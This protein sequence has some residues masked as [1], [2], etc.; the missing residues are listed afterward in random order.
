MAQVNKKGFDEVR[1]PFQKMTFSP[2]VPSTALGPNEYNSGLN[3]EVDVRGIR[4]V[5]GDEIILQG[6]PGKPTF[7]T[8]GYRQPIPGVVNNFYFIVA[9]DDGKWWANNG[10]GA[11]QDI[12]NPGQTVDYTQAQNITEAWNGTV[13]FFN[14][15]ANPPMFWPEFTG[16]GFETLTASSAAGTSTI[17]IDP[18]TLP[19]LVTGIADHT[20]TFTY[21]S[22]GKPLKTG[23]KVKVSGTNTNTNDAVL[24]RVRIAGNAGEFTCNAITT[25]AVMT[26]SIS[27]TT[28]TVTGVSSGYIYNGMVLSGT[29]VTADTTIVAYVSGNPGGASVWTVD[30]SQTTASTTITGVRPYGFQNGQTVTV[31]GTNTS[32]SQTLSNPA[33]AGTAGEFTVGTT[34]LGSLAITGTGGQFSCAATTIQVGQTVTISGTNSGTG[35]I[36]GYVNSTSYLV[37]ATN[38]TTTFTLSTLSGGA[39]VT[40]AGT[41]TGL[42]AVL[43]ATLS[44]GQSVTISGSISNTPTA[45]ST[46]SVIGNAGE[47]SCAASNI[48]V[49][50]TLTISGSITNTPTVLSTVVI[51]GTAGEFSCAPTSLQVGQTVVIDGVFGGTGSIEGYVPPTS[52]LISA[53]NGTTTFTLSTLTGAGLI[54]TAGT[55]TGLT[56]TVSIPSISG[57]SNPTD[58]LV[59]ETNGSTTFTIVNTDGSAVATEGGTPTGLTYTLQVPS[60]SNY[61]NPTTYQIAATDGTSSFTLVQVIDG[62]AY[63]IT[64]TGGSL[65]GLTFTVLAAS[66]TGYSDPTDYYVSVTNG[67]NTFTLVDGNGDAIATVG[68]RLTGLTF[69]LQAPE[70]TGYSNPTTY[71]VVQTNGVNTFQLSTS[72]GGSPISTYAGE[73]SGLTFVNTA[74]ARGQEVLVQGTVPTGFRGTH[75]LTDV[76]FNSVSFAGTTAGPLTTTG[77]V[78]DTLPTMIM[79]SNTLPLSIDDIAYLSPGLQRLTFATEQTTAPFVAGDY[80]VISGV[81]N[82]YNG[83]YLVAACTTTEVDYYAVPGA[84]Y[85]TNVSGSVAPKY[86][87]NYNPNWSKV[88]ARFMRLYSTPNVGNILVAGGLTTVDLNGTVNEYPVTVQWSQAFGLNDAPLTWEPTV[89]NVANQLEVPLRG[90][91]VDAFPCNGQLFLSSVWDTVVFSPINYSTTSAPILGVRLANQGRGMLSSNCWANTDKLVYGIDARDIWVF[92]G[93]D[94][95]G[96]GNQRVKNWF[97]DQLDP[98]YVDRVFMQTNTQ[99]NQVEIYYPTKVPVISNINVTST[100]GWFSCELEYGYDSGPMH[101]N[102]SVILSGT[103]SGTGSISGYSG[104]PTTYYVVNNYTQDGLTYFQ[105]STTAQGSGVTTTLGTVTGVDFNFETDGVPNMMLSYRY[106]LD[107]FNAPREVQAATFA[108]EAPYWSSQQWYLNVTGTNITGTGTGAHFNILRTNTTYQGGPT[109]NVRGTGYKVGDTIKVLGTALGGTT[110]ANDATLTIASIDGDGKVLTF[111]AT[112][113]AADEWTYDNSRRT[114][115]Y[116]RGLTDRSLVQKD[117][118]YNFLGPQTIEYDIQSNFRRDNIKLL[119][120]Y[121]GKLL[122]HRLLPE[123]VNLNGIGVPIN[124][125]QFPTRVGSINVQIEGANSVG[126]APLETTAETMAT[127]TDYPWVQ[128][129]QN[130]HRVNS[131]VLSNKTNTSI[132]MCNATTWQYTQT[133]DDR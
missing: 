42:S 64:T 14:D 28:L 66:I 37:S 5:S 75:T 52:Y 110:P 48:T 50:Q 1:I 94:F 10:E 44:V 30:T 92:N 34:T 117:D 38:G 20:G 106:D 125:E 102:L 29:G 49:G 99:K 77:A 2:D 90:P 53:T 72:Y 133:E 116:A 46:V 13:P 122:V 80:I 69:R 8:G 112:G 109:P 16:N 95:Q 103:E 130:A 19:I 60:I 114:V 111:T 17:T 15:E 93:Q 87:W 84:A 83:T 96:L 91:V 126:Q 23:Q 45:L 33:V 98:D 26:A 25:P 76:D 108:T 132:W 7:V 74:F 56:Y 115:V 4:S 18:Q 40:T 78:S 105:L 62:T 71:Y 81:N 85:P 118:G 59:K 86:A 127:N 128:I 124:P 131:I 36:T 54:T 3:V 11:W 47:F 88:Y 104:G 97:F 58:Y 121:S 22:A 123:V 41:T 79:Y 43:S 100:D 119:Q 21:T 73:L 120:D 129:S 68:G 6:I 61:T 31:S 57:Y 55:P 67:S 12:T 63:P 89:T 101:N 107:C 113:D 82:Y 39:V 9:T 35:T 32:T 51:T 24:G 27:G 70:I 65:S